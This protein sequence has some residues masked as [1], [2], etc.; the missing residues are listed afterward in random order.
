[1]I[2]S[3]SMLQGLQRLNLASGAAVHDPAPAGPQAPQPAPP[4]SSPNASGQGRLAALS[5]HKKNF[6]ELAHA[7]GDTPP[8]AR[9]TVE[10]LKRIVSYYEVAKPLGRSGVKMEFNNDELK[11]EA[12][13]QWIPARLEALKGPG[14]IG[15]FVNTMWQIAPSPDDRRRLMDL[16]APLCSGGPSPFVVKKGSEADLHDKIRAD[17]VFRCRLSSYLKN[18]R[19]MVRAHSLA[20]GATDAVVAGYMA[21]RLT[22]H[23]ARRGQPIGYLRATADDKPVVHGEAHLDTFIAMPNGQ[24]LSA[25]PYTWRQ[26]YV[27]LVDTLRNDHSIEVVDSDLSKLGLCTADKAISPQA[28]STGCGSLG[29]AYLKELLK[30][31]AQQLR[32][33]CLVVSGLRPASASAATGGSSFLLPSPQVLR[34]SQRSLFNRLA[35]AM[36][37]ANPASVVVQHQGASYVV[38]T[39]GKQLA[40][41]AAIA[42]PGG[43]PLSASDLPKFC[44]DWQSAYQQA[45]GKREAMNVTAPS[46]QVNGYLSYVSQRLNFKA[47]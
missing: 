5:Q 18:S 1:M 27:G 8:I 29:V 25:L 17:P 15:D 2:G 30:N 42:R 19:E 7:H 38:P 6:L 46:W 13:S 41:G 16:C 47:T 20:V 34:Y 22:A 31:D 45:M 14:V 37:D 39:L 26:S 44:E 21:R 10:Q 35:S 24:I 23:A 43:G 12:R 36:V 40:D 32:N 9:L 33:S 11:L 4:T 3:H 28:T